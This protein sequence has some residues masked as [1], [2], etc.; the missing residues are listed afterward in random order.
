MPRG[1]CLCDVTK[2]LRD[3]T[4]KSSNLVAILSSFEDPAI[5]GRQRREAERQKRLAKC[6]STD[7]PMKTTNAIPDSKEGDAGNGQT[8]ATSLPSE[9]CKNRGCVRRNDLAEKLEMRLEDIKAAVASKLKE[10]ESRQQKVID[11]MHSGTYMAT[12]GCSPA[13]S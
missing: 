9:T 10:L 12:S 4:T 13:T 2:R 7:G 6:R 8:L 5:R 1:L 11:R 3:T